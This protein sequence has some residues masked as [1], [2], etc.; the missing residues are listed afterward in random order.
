M[1]NRRC[2]TLLPIGLWVLV[3][4]LACSLL[5]AQENI[6]E[7]VKKCKPAIVLITTY[8][9][10]G[11]ASA[12]GTGFFINNNGILVTNRH[13]MLGA[14]SAT[15][16]TYSGETLPILGILAEDTQWDLVKVQ[17]DTTHHKFFF[18][19]I[20][21]TSPIEGERVIVIGNPLGLEATVSDG[22]VSSV[23]TI[24][25]EG[26]FIQIT[27]P[28][29]PGSSGSPILNS[30]GEVIGIATFIMTEGQNL[31]FAIP[32]K[33]IPS[34][35]TKLI[36]LADWTEGDTKDWLKSAEGFYFQGILKEDLEK[37]QEAIPYFEEAVK[38]NPLNEEAFFQLGYCYD[39]L[40]QYANGIKNYK[41]AIQLKPDD[42]IAH[43]NLG[44]AYRQLGRYTEAIEEYKQVIQLKPDFVDAYIPLGNA[45]RQLGRY[46]EAIEEYKQ[47]IQLKPNFIDAYISLGNAY[48]DLGS[49]TEAIEEYKQAIQLK[50]DFADSYIFLG[51]TYGITGNRSQEIE[52]YKEAIRIIPD[53][54]QVH[55]YLGLAYKYIEGE[56]TMEEFKRTNR[57]K[58]DFSKSMEEFKQAIR[59]KFDYAEA[60]F[61]LG[62][63]YGALGRNFE[64]IDELK[65]AV[66]I[67]PDYVLAHYVLGTVYFYV[68]HNR[69]AA[70]EE[71]KILKDL[72]KDKANELF[73]AIYK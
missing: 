53:N 1:K 54:A 15:V 7:L 61:E 20:S 46:A 69:S 66:R 37:Y 2:Y 31:N 44:V 13:V 42:E 60:H 24:P 35:S 41:Q 67:K 12:Q 49:N 73:D 36:K 23:R 4:A 27:A 34:S 17:V 57:L 70:L 16:Q 43:Y 55:Y 25:G 63:V 51:L 28:I 29:S 65:E 45:Y 40:R 38:I 26:E 6:P 18:L 58:T 33:R 5:S 59:L 68:Q 71:Y 48:S 62:L 11:S 30:K 39:K 56:K 72:D 9:T 3:F 32:V 52:V 19:T 47:M 50:P 10:E 14:H 22:L 64:E 21:T 8:D